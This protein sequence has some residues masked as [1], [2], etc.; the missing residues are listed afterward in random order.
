MEL[1]GKIAVITGA[2]GGIGAA[3][4]E[5]LKGAGVICILIEKHISLLDKFKDLTDQ[6]IY[7]YE[8]DLADQESLRHLTDKINSNFKHIDF[9]FN[10]LDSIILIAYLINQA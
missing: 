9:L 7:I 2:G 6:Q 8:C 3:L 5:R 10:I 4:V 1:K